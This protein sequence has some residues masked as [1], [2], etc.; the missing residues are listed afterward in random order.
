MGKLTRFPA[1]NTNNSRGW[2]EEACT[3]GLWSL[4]M[5]VS[6]MVVSFM[7]VLRLWHLH[8][9]GLGD[10]K[11]SSDRLHLITRARLTGL[12]RDR[13]SKPPH[14]GATHHQKLTTLDRDRDHDSRPLSWPSSSEG[15]LKKSF[16]LLAIVALQPTITSTKK[17]TI[18]PEH[19]TF[20]PMELESPCCSTFKAMYIFFKT[21]PT[22]TF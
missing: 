9:S 19:I 11:C 20:K 17:G 21:W 4:A 6:F 3:W 2:E 5:V 14:Y 7:V 15:L 1:N 12:N 22:G 16:H 18:V 8:L 13:E 10:V